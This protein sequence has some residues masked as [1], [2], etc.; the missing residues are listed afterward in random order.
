MVSNGF[1][2]PRRPDASRG[3]LLSPSRPLTLQPDQGVNRRAVEDYVE[4]LV[5]QGGDRVLCVAQTGRGRRS[6]AG[7]SQCGGC[8]AAD[9]GDCDGER[10][11]HRTPSSRRPDLALSKGA[12]DEGY[13]DDLR[14]AP[15]GWRSWISASLSSPSKVPP[16]PISSR[17][18][19]PP[20]HSAIR[21]S[22]GPTTTSR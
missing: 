3:G 2:S 11:R 1:G 12:G 15:L 7:E 22:F 17:S 9:N 20:S 18:P 16:T 21:P 8:E 19:V 6:R 13:S 5:L 10:V 4:A 14:A